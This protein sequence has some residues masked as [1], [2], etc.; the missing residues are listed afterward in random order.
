MAN[1]IVDNKLFEDQ[2]LVAFDLSHA[3]DNI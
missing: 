1:F 2:S 3:D